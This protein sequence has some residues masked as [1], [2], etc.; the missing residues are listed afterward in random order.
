VVGR[1]RAEAGL[2][3]GRKE[4]GGGRDFNGGIL[5]FVGF[6]GFVLVFRFMFLMPAYAHLSYLPLSSILFVCYDGEF[7]SL[8]EITGR[9]REKRRGVF[10]LTRV[11]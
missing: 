6:G 1:E 10:R 9:G 11:C 4:G 2:E 3:G 7:G 8:E 5:I